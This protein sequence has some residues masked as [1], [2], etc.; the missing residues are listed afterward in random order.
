M[1]LAALSRLELPA[2]CDP[3]KV[4]VCGVILFCLVL[5]GSAAHRINLTLVTCHTRT[6]LMTPPLIYGFT[7]VFMGKKYKSTFTVK[8]FPRHFGRGEAEAVHTQKLLCHESC[9]LL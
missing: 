6:V 2:P 3:K 7:D 1:L 5:F 9:E 4:K 8:L